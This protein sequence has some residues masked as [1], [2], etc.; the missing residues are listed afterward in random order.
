MTHKR[1][2]LEQAKE[3]FLPKPS[4]L[5]LN[6]DTFF[7]LTPDEKD[8]LTDN[9]HYW[10]ERQRFD[11]HLSFNEGFIYILE[12]SGTPGIL[13]IGY[14]D[15]SPQDRVREINSATGVIIPYHIVNTYPCKAP[16]HIE[17]LV[18]QALHTHRVNKEGFNVSLKH[19]KEVIEKIIAENNAHIE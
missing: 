6:K 18:H 15:R 9:V 7:T 16:K 3:S 1:I 10:I 13:K 12:S 19:A 11:A 17:T 14:T 2:T 8:P 5:M 4:F